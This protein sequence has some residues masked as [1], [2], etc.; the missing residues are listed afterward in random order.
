MK[1]ARDQVGDMTIP[2]EALPLIEW[3]QMERLTCRQAAILLLVQS[4]PG[5][6]A[7]ALAVAMKIPTPCIT[8][9]SDKLILAGMLKRTTSNLDRRVIELWPVA[10]KGKKA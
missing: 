5:I 2:A 8:R 3:G 4:N 6:S 1:P 7:S 9:A 10:K